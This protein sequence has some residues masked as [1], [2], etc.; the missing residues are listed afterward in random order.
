MKKL[1]YF[2]FLTFL[3]PQLYAQEKKEV[4]DESL[5]KSLNAD[6]YGMKNYVFC[7]LKSG[8]NTSLSKEETSKVFA[9]HMQNI[10]RLANE[11]KL[12]VA[13]PFGKNDKNYRGIYI[14]NVATIAEA[15]QLVATD[16]AVQAKVLEFELTPWYS[17]A[18]LQEI[19]KIHPKI[20][21]K[22]Y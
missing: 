11:G 15:E 22:S 9:G 6:D 19:N 13:G 7:I 2:A 8:S 18:A 20:A 12:V 5:A 4:Y 16:P 10:S 21:K 17:T 14:F 3:V 1:F